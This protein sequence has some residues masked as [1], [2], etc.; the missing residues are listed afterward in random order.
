LLDQQDQFLQSF[1]VSDYSNIA[2]EEACF[3][4]KGNKS[5]QYMDTTNSS[6]WNMSKQIAWFEFSIS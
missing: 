6:H 2:Q 5:L 1:V 3:L 4:Q